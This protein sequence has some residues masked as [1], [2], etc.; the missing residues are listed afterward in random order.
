M[1]ALILLFSLAP[2]ITA[3]A[4]LWVYPISGLPYVLLLLRTTR[5]SAGAA[6]TP[7][8]EPMTVKGGLPFSLAAFATKLQAEYNKPILAQS[9][10]DLAGSY[11]VAQRAVDIASLPLLALQEALLPRLYSQANP[12]RQLRR[13]G[14]AL[15]LLALL[16]GA[17]VWLAAPLLPLMLGPSF[18]DTVAVLRMLAWLP[19]LQTLRYL[20]NSYVI[21][22]AWAHLIGWT[23]GLSAIVGVASVTALV[24]HHGMQGAV[25]SAYLTELTLTMTLLITCLR[26]HHHACHRS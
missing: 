25:I 19:A 14:L 12:M 21:H 10:F 16:L 17:I 5:A 22:R 23:Y 7:V 4:V 13:T 6:D 8:P 9:A 3:E 24:P 15:L 18:S 20:I 26:K 2:H 11:N 1:F